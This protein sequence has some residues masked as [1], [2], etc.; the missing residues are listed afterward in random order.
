M[1]MMSVSMDTSFN[2]LNDNDSSC[3]YCFSQRLDNTKKLIPAIRIKSIGSI[4]SRL[5]S[6]P[7]TR[8]EMH[9]RHHYDNRKIGDSGII[10]D[11]LMEKSIS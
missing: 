9:Y 5:I 7:I 8:Q 4:L 6:N 11:V 2:R 10:T 3:R 1:M